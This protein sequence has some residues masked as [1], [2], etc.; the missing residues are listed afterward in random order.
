MKNLKYLICL[1]L[2][3]GSIL[4]ICKIW[5]YSIIYMVIYVML[6]ITI[7]VI[8]NYRD[9]SK[10]F[11]QTSITLKKDFKIFLDKITIVSIIIAFVI[12]IIFAFYSIF[13]Q[14]QSNTTFVTDTLV[15]NNITYYVLIIDVFF[16]YNFCGINIKQYQ[17]DIVHL[18]NILV[19]F[20]KN[21]IILHIF[22]IFFFVIFISNKDIIL[23]ICCSYIFLFITEINSAFKSKKKRINYSIIYPII[24][25]FFLLIYLFNIEKI[26]NSIVNG[27]MLNVSLNESLYALLFTTILIISNNLEKI[28]NIKFIKKVINKYKNFKKAL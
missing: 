15:Y 11:K 1:F 23:A 2:I 19:D 18:L 26:Y 14:K 3:L 25:N 12:M 7:I 22:S 24:I 8:L 21:N 17:E 28:S 20:L 10:N 13:E 27:N 6:P 4:F 16:L 5:N 9:Y